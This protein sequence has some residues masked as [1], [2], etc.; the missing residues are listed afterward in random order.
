MIENQLIL[1]LAVFCTLM[2][3]IAL[4]QVVKN[5]D[6]LDKMYGGSDLPFSYKFIRNSLFYL[7][8]YSLYKVLKELF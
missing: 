3:V 7:I 4:C 5:R 1:Y 8:F 6:K 2:G